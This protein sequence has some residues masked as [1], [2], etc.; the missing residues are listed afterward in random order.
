M[1]SICD[2]DFEVFAKNEVVTFAREEDELSLTR[3]PPRR[4]GKT[5]SLKTFILIVCHTDN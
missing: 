5:V 4:A 2:Y 1:S 3:R